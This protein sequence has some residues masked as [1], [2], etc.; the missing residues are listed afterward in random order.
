[1]DNFYKLVEAESLPKETFMRI[2]LQR[3]PPGMMSTIYLVNRPI[4]G[5]HV[6]LSEKP[7]N[8][9][10]YGSVYFISV[11]DSYRIGYMID[12]AL[13]TTFLQPKCLHVGKRETNI[14]ALKNIN[15]IYSD[16][17]IS[18]LSCR[19]INSYMIIPICNEDFPKP[20]QLK[21]LEEA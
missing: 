16:Q 19:E 2:P 15:I 12:T 3:T 8:L 7:I 13:V 10:E 20:M 6:N 18:I 1:M 17:Y 14:R 21:P 11:S 5:V 9:G 4:I